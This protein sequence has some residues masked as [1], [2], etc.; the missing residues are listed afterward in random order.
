MKFNV[1]I[2]ITTIE[3]YGHVN[4]NGSQVEYVRRHHHTLSAQGDAWRVGF[5]ATTTA[6]TP[7]VRDLVGEEAR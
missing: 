3:V 4:Y 7:T 6:K 5:E 2:T 1:V